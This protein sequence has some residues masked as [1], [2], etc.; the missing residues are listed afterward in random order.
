MTYEV[1]LYSISGIEI[2]R[3]RVD[4]AGLSRV[5]AGV[6]DGHGLIRLP[7]NDR[8][9]YRLISARNIAWI[10]VTEVTP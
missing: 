3:L 5:T 10:D 8:A 7:D 1:A 6:R 9:P 4:C 2:G